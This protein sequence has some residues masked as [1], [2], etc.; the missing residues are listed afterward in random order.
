MP[1]VLPARPSLEQLKNQAKDLLA[2]HR[3]G[4]LD[5]QARLHRWFPPPAAPE[6]TEPPALRLNH[7]QLAI[8]REHGFSSWSR[9][10][11]WVAREEVPASLAAQVE[12]LGVRGWRVISAAQKALAEAGDAGIAAAIEGLS[13]PNPRVRMGAAAFMDHHADDSCVEKL[14]DLILH[15]PVPYVRRV[16]LHAL[17]CQKCKPKPLTKDVT[18]VLL[19][20]A[21][22]DPSPRVRY[23]ALYGL[24][25]QRHDPRIV[26]ALSTA[27][28]EE[29]NP[30]A[31]G[32][33]H[34]ALK[35]QSPD[36]RQETIRRA[37][38][39]SLDRPA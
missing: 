25:Q 17:E 1:R 12:L 33:A 24:G 30:K 15:D 6:G 18:E 22:K 16:A 2:A 11:A 37:R 27:L 36:Y 3:R 8:A 20:V 28:R 4:D 35:R 5:A 34:V 31:R 39:G 26:E 38:E 32:A 19:Q 29:P 21:R 7:A 9:L 23:F 13:H 14:L 10:A